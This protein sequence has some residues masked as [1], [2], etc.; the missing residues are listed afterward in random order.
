[1]KLLCGLALAQSSYALE[2]CEFED[3]IAI[4]CRPN[5][6]TLKLSDDPDVVPASCIDYMASNF[7]ES[8]F[9]SNLV[10]FI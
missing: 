5:S 10:L 4:E 9:V 7:D 1:M 3:M 2:S 8:H 6:V